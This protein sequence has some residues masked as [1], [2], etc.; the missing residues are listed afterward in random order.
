MARLKLGAIITDASGKLGGH[1]IGKNNGNVVLK[2]KSVSNKN[3]SRS[4]SSQRS[5][6]N[7]LMKNWASL[8]DDQRRKW[9]LQLDFYNSNSVLGDH[10]K[11]TGFTLFQKLNQGRLLF[12]QSL[13]LDPAAK[14][15]PSLPNILSISASTSSLIIQSDNYNA[16]DNIAI[17]ASTGLSLGISNSRK[18]MKTI[19]YLTGSQLA[20]GYDVISEYSAIFGT[21]KENKNI[22]FGN[23]TFSSVSGYSN[24][25]LIINNPVQV[26]GTTTDFYLFQDN[27]VYLFQ[28]NNN[29]IF[30]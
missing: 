20:A 7:F 16:S 4:Q 30:N 21:P 23:K 11:Y 2:N 17:Y 8:T 22:F 6:T 19:A 15:K 9:Y 27:N 1:V 3:P 18:Y 12:S 29:F 24:Q 10:P 13:L 26:G 5:Q 25:V 28:D 14:S